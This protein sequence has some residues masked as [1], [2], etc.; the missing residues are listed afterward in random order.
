[1][2]NALRHGPGRCH[3]IILYRRRPEQSPEQ[4]RTATAELIEYARLRVGLFPNLQILVG[5]GP[6][7]LR[8]HADL[9]ERVGD[10]GEAEKTL[11][12][13][14]Q[15]DGRADVFVQ[16]AA[17]TPIDRDQACR[18]VEHCLGPLEESARHIQGDRLLNGQ[19][20]FGFK[21]GNPPSLADMLAAFDGRLANQ[22]AAL[23]TS[24]DVAALE[25]DIAGSQATQWL[26]FQ[27]YRQRTA[28]FFRR[29]DVGRAEVIG[30]PP[31]AIVDGAQRAAAASVGASGGPSTSHWN[32][33][34]AGGRLPIV[35][36]G[37]PCRTE[38]GDKGL[39]FAAVSEDLRVLEQ[40]LDR[41]RGRDALNEFV[42][43]R[44]GGMFLLPPDG[45][46]LRAGITVR[47][48]PPEVVA[49]ANRGAPLVSYEVADSFHTY[50]NRLRADHIFVGPPG[51]MS[52][53]PT[54]QPIIDQLHQEVA[55]LS[56][57][58]EQAE[59]AELDRLAAEAEAQANQV[60][61]DVNDYHT[62]N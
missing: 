16:I 28:E 1:M 51:S 15:P 40:S 23:T 45:T 11:A 6:S 17:E 57:Q 10:V 35:R 53:A 2:Q 18:L 22:V 33:M 56:G 42:Q 31:T 52:V 12:S 54:V 8:E 26:L 62:F 20:H 41:F 9:L 14:A 48:L 36:R 38:D 7:F 21:D 61:G 4:L 39:A 13:R 60:N 47:P 58:P 59:K 55:R 24:V 46:W 49:L 43:V 50:M 5:V 32:T 19:E 29:G 27:R 37:F 34:R 30:R 3:A 25:A 44:E